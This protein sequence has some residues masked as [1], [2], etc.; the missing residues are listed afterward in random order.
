MEVS[1]DFSKALTV[2]SSDAL[3]LHLSSRCPLPSIMDSTGRL[4]HG[5]IAIGK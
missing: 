3:I 2:L 4:G 1:F 5:V